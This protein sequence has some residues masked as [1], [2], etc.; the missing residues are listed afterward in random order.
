MDNNLIVSQSINIHAPLSKVWDGLTRP[1][2]IKE[3]LFG[4]E[5]VTDWKVGS[6]V[7]F[8]G[9]YKGQTYQD[10]GIILEN[11]F[12]ERISYSY[13]S[14][15]TGTEDKPENYSRV[16]Y[17]LHPVTEQLT[18]FTWTTQGFTSEQGYEHSKNGMKEFLEK[19]REA[20]EKS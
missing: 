13:W 2:I 9:E 1:E 7:I 10:H 3:Y 17:T 11:K 5:T 6:E 15:F 18:S 14:K 16:T 4:T 8:K 12:Q 20:I 19:I